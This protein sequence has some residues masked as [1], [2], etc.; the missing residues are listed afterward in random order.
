MNLRVVPDQDEAPWAICLR[1]YPNDVQPPRII[2]AWDCE[3][4][5]YGITYIPENAQSQV[6]VPF[7]NLLYAMKRVDE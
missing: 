6:F 4:G 7:S 5:E 1:D 2:S 3:F